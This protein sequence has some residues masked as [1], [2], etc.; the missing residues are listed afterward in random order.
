MSGRCVSASSSHQVTCAMMSLID[1]A[2]VTPGSNNSASARPAYD[3]LNPSH[4][5][6]SRFSS[7]PPPP[8]MVCSPP[9]EDT[10]VVRRLATRSLFAGVS[11]RTP[12]LALAVGC[13]T[14]VRPGTRWC[15]GLGGGADK[16][17]I[18]AIALADVIQTESRNAILPLQAMGIQ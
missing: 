5:W 6:A 12:V 16:Q 10:C 7:C 15:C 1:Q 3:C 13:L 9:R 14:G 11:P 17:I 8:D 4:A 18:G 2:P